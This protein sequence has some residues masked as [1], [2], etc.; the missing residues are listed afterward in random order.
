MPA[1]ADSLNDLSSNAA[2]VGDHAG[3]ERRVGVV[4]AAVLG[5]RGATGEHEG[6]SAQDAEAGEG[7]LSGGD[8]HCVLQMSPGRMAGGLG[9]TLPSVSGAE[10]LSASVAQKSYKGA[11]GGITAK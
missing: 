8:S 1:Q 7:G 9:T 11:D 4:V 6:C 3:V 5:R 2:R 10:T